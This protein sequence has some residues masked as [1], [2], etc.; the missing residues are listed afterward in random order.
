VAPKKTADLLPPFS[1][2][3]PTFANDFEHKRTW[4]SRH[5]VKRC[6]PETSEVKQECSC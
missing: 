3:Y 1:I 6:Q 5:W 4:R 2:S